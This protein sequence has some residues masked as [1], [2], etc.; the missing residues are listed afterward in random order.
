LYGEFGGNGLLVEVDA[1]VLQV[2]ALVQFVRLSLGGAVGEAA[3][4]AEVIEALVCLSL[5][6]RL[7]LVRAHRRSAG[8]LRHQIALQLGLRVLVIRLGGLEL[9]LRVEELLLQFRINKVH[10]DGVGFYMRTG[11]YTDADDGR[12]GLC[13]DETYAV[14]AWN[15]RA[16]SADLAKQWATLDGV[17]PHCAIDRRDR[18]LQPEDEPADRN[19]RN[20]SNSRYGEL[21]AQLALSYVRS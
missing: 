14:F 20:Q 18:G 5:Q 13:R 2:V 7:L 10:Q 1:L 4:H 3:D 6:L 15:K 17:G 19:H 11:K 9:E 12:L 21:P 8:S 16:R